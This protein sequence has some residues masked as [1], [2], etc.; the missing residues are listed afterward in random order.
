MEHTRSVQIPVAGRAD[1]NKS[2][3]VRIEHRKRG[4][5]RSERE[6]MH[7][8]AVAIPEALGSGRRDFQGAGA[9]KQ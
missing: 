7:H 1:M 2:R 6:S 9:T 8:E 4:V 3:P 5:S